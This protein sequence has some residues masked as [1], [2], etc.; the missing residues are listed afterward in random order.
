M[1][2]WF[3]HKIVHSL[4][5]K[6]AVN[7]TVGKRSISRICILFYDIITKRCSGILQSCHT[8]KK[9]LMQIYHRVV[10]L[11]ETVIV[12]KLILC[13]RPSMQSMGPAEALFSCCL[14]LCTCLP[15]CMCVCARAEAFS[16]WTGLPFVWGCYVKVE[17]GK[18]GVRIL[19][20][21]QHSTITASQ[22]RNTCVIG[23]LHFLLIMLTALSVA[24]RQSVQ[25]YYM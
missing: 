12:Q 1:P 17:V 24:C 9:L 15:T 14:S 2:N 3:M 23:L 8:E 18:P 22:T 16:N 10:N 4:A 5:A 25:D 6:Y 11:N 21:V 19:L 7:F 13:L 20:Q